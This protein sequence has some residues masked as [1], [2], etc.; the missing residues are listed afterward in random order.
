MPSKLRREQTPDG[1]RLVRKA[2][3]PEDYTVP[4]SALQLI[5]RW[6]QDPLNAADLLEERDGPFVNYTEVGR[7]EHDGKRWIVLKELNDFA[8]EVE[9]RQSGLGEIISLPPE[10]AWE[11]AREF[12]KTRPIPTVVEGE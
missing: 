2:Y 4:P 7:T 12:D 8:I 9:L 5:D 3:R 6:R 10:R 1:P 11:I